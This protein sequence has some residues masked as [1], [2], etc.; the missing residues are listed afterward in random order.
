MAV[1]VENHHKIA[2]AE[3]EDLAAINRQLRKSLQVFEEDQIAGRQV[4][5]QLLPE[6]DVQFGQYFFTH[7]IIPSLYLSGDFIDYFEIG[8][9]LLGFYIMDVSGHGVSSAF[10]TV[11]M[12]SVMTQLH[13]A[14]LAGHSEVI[15][16]P[17]QVLSHLGKSLLS[18]QL[19]KYLTMFYGV[20]DKQKNTLTYSIG[21]QYPQP[22]LSDGEQ[23]EFLANNSFPVGLA[24]DTHYDA[25]TRELPEKFT[26]VMFS[27]GI[28][29]VMP[30]HNLVD[31]ESQ[32]AELVHDRNITMDMLLASIMKAKQ[33]I[34]A[35]DIAVGLVRK[36]S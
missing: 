8:E 18:A 3:Q 26:L 20:I 30:E 13:E 29:D 19:G 1:T 28:F 9:K 35:D 7:R 12:K 21:G 16:H 5:S 22:I 32:L 24:A 27:D 34:T 36:V 10:V 25:V 33:E 17:D 15:T 23:V 6:Q 31:K 14:Y 4:Q 2:A 11:L